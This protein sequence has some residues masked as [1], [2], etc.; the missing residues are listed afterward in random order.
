MAT[1]GTAT[2]PT[3]TR[4]FFIQPETRVVW[5]G[6]LE[7]SS[8]VYSTYGGGASIGFEAATGIELGQLAAP[9]RFQ[10][11]PN[12]T[13]ID[14]GNM[15][16]T[17]FEVTSE[18]TTFTVAIREFRPEILQAAFATAMHYPIEDNT[19]V[20]T[21]GQGCTIDPHPLMIEFSN[22]DCGVPTAEDITNGITGG[23]LTLY[24]AYLTGGI[25]WEMAY[26]SANR[27]EL[28]FT[29]QPVMAKDLGN[30]IGSLYLY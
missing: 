3:V 14:A 17:L 9:P 1:Y 4:G 13:R 22:V 10:H 2:A 11:N 5:N 23:I 21:F 8:W 25:N 27:L 26:G 20:I 15:L 16:G 30:R 29:A 18:E 6:T 12:M 24:S 7:T 28:V 19:A